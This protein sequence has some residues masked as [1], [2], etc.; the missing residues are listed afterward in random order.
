MGIRQRQEVSKFWNKLKPKVQGQMIYEEETCSALI[1]TSKPNRKTFSQLEKR[2]Q[3]LL[4]RKYFDYKKK[5]SSWGTDIPT[6]EHLV[7]E[8]DPSI[9]S[10]RSCECYNC[11]TERQ[12]IEKEERIQTNVGRKKKGL[13]PILKKYEVDLSYDQN[14]TYT[15][16]VEVEAESEE[17]AEK[18][19]NDNLGEGEDFVN[20]A[21]WD[22]DS[23]G[24]FDPQIDE[25][26]EFE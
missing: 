26:R 6:L 9:N 20:T 25:V 15:T 17:E 18:Y 5:R 4:V 3:E 8:L 2:I 7:H 10:L 16:T 14:S 19:V 23:D 12:K 11:K 21:E 1:N 13:K 24:G 22:R